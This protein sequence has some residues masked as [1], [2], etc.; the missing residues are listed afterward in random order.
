MFNKK[1]IG[2]LFDDIAFESIQFSRDINH[3]RK[4]GCIS[5]NTIKFLE[6]FQKKVNKVCDEYKPKFQKMIDKQDE[7]S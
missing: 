3:F 1:N 5:E 2:T 4:T 7:V 6:H